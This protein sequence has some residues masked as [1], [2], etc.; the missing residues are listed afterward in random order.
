MNICM[1]IPIFVLLS[2][3]NVGVSDLED[4]DD[5]WTM[6]LL[7]LF[8]TYNLVGFELFMFNNTLLTL[9]DDGDGETLA[10]DAFEDEDDVVGVLVSL[11]WA[12]W[13]DKSGVDGLLIL[14]AGFCWN[15]RDILGLINQTC[16][17]IILTYV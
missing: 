12:G 1:Y 16:F 4:D 15:I 17:K 3:E 10:E 5:D 2:V 13:V 6:S 7:L 8:V 9:A 14:V 11:A